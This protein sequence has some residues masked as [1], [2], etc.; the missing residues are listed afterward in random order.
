MDLMTTEIMSFESQFGQLEITSIDGKEYFAANEVAI[1]LGY[2]NPQKAIRDHCKEK[3]CTFRSVLTVTGE[4][5]K[6]FIDEGNVYRL[7]A[8]SKLPTAEQFEEWIFEE[9]LPQIRR[10]GAYI[11]PNISTEN[12]NLLD[13]FGTPKK[14]K[15]TINITPIENLKPLLNEY[16]SYRK[17]KTAHE[18]LLLMNQ[19]NRYVDLRIEASKAAGMIGSAHDLLAFSRG[20]VNEKVKVNN[21]KHGGIKANLRRQNNKLSAQIEEL[22]NQQIYYHTLE[23]HGFSNNYMYHQ[24]GNKVYRTQ[25]YK[26][27]VNNFPY[28]T[29][30]AYELEDGKQYELYLEVDC[31]AKVDVHNLTKSIIDLI[32]NHYSINDKFITKV[33]VYKRNNVDNYKLGKIHFSIVELD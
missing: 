4:K 18:K 31:V 6:R 29:M 20:L 16:L 17:P 13:K 19:F 21:K 12:E 24:V 7:I 8:R 22:T 10:N 33:H 26:K 32:A 11:S 28:D 23:Y 27:W 2:S 9:V 14:L 15:T 30:P 25:A 3:G 1:A 5:Q